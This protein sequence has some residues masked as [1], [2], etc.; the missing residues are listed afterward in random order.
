MLKSNYFKGIDNYFYK[1]II[2]HCLRIEML[3]KLEIHH[4]IS[5]DILYP[6][7]QGYIESLRIKAETFFLREHNKNITFC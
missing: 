2:P 3:D 6:D 7:N 4:K 1:I 5:K